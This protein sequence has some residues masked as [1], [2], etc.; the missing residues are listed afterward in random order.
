MKRAVITG[1]GAITPIGNN[2]ND[3]WRNI[4]EGKSGAAPITRFDTINH[5]TKF[6]CEVK[7]FDPLDFF[8][9]KEIRKLDRFTQFALVA[10]DECVR[11]SNLNLEKTDLNKIGVIMATGIGG[12]Q[13][14]EE[15]VTCFWAE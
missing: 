15:E 10:T 13:S 1:L 4:L 2:V 14:Y 6:A 9:R 5:K 12:I 8:D 11:D 3:Y 7:D